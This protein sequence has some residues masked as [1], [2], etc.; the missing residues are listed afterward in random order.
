M[1][2]FRFKSLDV[3]LTIEKATPVTTFWLSKRYAVFYWWCACAT[4]ELCRSMQQATC[5][6]STV[7][8]KSFT[9]RGENFHEQRECFNPC[10]FGGNMF[11][12]QLHVFRQLQRTYL[13]RQLLYKTVLSVHRDK[14]TCSV[15]YTCRRHSLPRRL[16]R[17]DQTAQIRQIQ[18]IFSPCRGEQMCEDENGNIY[19][20]WFDGDASFNISYTS[21]KQIIDVFYT[22]IEQQIYQGTVLRAA[23][24]HIWKASM[25]CRYT[26]LINSNAQL[27]W[28]SKLA[29]PLAKFRI[30][31]LQLVGAL[32]RMKVVIG[33]A[34]VH[35]Y[36]ELAIQPVGKQT[37]W[38]MARPQTGF[39]ELTGAIR[40]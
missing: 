24:K 2:F 30:M 29:P 28:E 9:G 39:R 13:P 31:T 3:K 16:L 23:G 35:E 27:H 10:M 34:V 8:I 12:W 7:G 37:S 22:T 36:Y 38:W 14:D 4:E 11:P 26:W 19:M 18:W 5:A 40:S 20:W 17:T 25:R 6:R 21:E 32:S 33:R 1:L 15:A